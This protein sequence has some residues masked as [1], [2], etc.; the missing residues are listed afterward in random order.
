[1]VWR[2]EALL[3]TVIQGFRLIEALPSLPHD[4]QR[5]PGDQSPSYRREKE[6]I[7]S[8]KGFTETNKGA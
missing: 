4:V 2:R 7:G 3:H 1:M 6:R 8:W 5:D